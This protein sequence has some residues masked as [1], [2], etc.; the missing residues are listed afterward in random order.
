MIKEL[1][2]DEC[3]T[4]GGGLNSSLSDKM[5]NLVF[6]VSLLLGSTKVEISAPD[7]V[8][9]A[10]HRPLYAARKMS[11]F[12]ATLNGTFTK[13][14]RSAAYAWVASSLVEYLVGMTG[15]F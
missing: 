11:T 13:F 3:G 14:A 10:E 2:F 5:F 7:M 8:S 6:G 1:K 4:I 9:G 15:V 12:L